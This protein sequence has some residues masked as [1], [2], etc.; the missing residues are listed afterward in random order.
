MKAGAL[1]RSS[2]SASVTVV[3]STAGAFAASSFHLP[4][5]SAMPPSPSWVWNFTT[6]PLSF[7]TTS[8][9]IW[10]VRPSMA[11]GKGST[12]M[13]VHPRSSSARVFE[14]ICP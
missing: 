3:S 1:A 11:V 6:L 9:I 10:Q 8:L 4:R 13:P 2:T 7:E 5:V 14:P 12:Q